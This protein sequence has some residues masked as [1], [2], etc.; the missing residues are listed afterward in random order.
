[1]RSGS[2][3]ISAPILISARCSRYILWIPEQVWQ[4]WRRKNVIQWLRLGFSKGP[5]RVGVSPHLRTETDPVS[6]MLRFSSNYLESGRWTKSENL[7]ILCVIHHR[8]NPIESTYTA[9]P[10]FISLLR[11]PHTPYNY[12]LKTTKTKLRGRSPQANYTDRA[13]AACRRS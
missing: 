5:N 7:L 4:L 12:A 3:P 10:L 13:T 9:C 2:R 1:M 6:E 8:Q 11:L